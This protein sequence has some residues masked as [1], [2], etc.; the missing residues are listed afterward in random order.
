VELSIFIPTQTFIS[1]PTNATEAGYEPIS[2]WLTGY[3]DVTAAFNRL[4]FVSTA[5]AAVV[6]SN[7]QLGESW[8]R[9]L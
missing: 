2:Q 6:Q 1:K 7:S 5:L 9:E 8:S 4:D 3:A